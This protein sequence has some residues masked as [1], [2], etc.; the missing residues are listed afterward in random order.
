M[1]WYFGEN[2][3]F[4]RTEDLTFGVRSI[5]GVVVLQRSFCMAGG[6]VRFTPGLIDWDAQSCCGPVADRNVVVEA[7]E[8]VGSL[9]FNIECVEL[10]TYLAW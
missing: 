6:R 2:A 5:A 4:G 9:V 1:V 7:T 8:C 10:V 3:G